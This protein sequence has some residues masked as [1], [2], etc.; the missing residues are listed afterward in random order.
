MDGGEFLGHRD[1][2]CGLRGGFIFLGVL[3][4]GYG[5]CGLQGGNLL[6]SVDV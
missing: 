5:H 6:R 2:R 4:F 1:G 3:M